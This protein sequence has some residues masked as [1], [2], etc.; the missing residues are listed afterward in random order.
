MTLLGILAVYAALFAFI[1]L[2]RKNPGWWLSQH[3]FS[4]WGPRTD[5]PCMTRR[6]L[7]GEGL[8][9]L[10]L[11][12]LCAA[13]FVTLAWV[14]DRLGVAE[15]PA[16]MATTFLAFIL[17]AMGFFAAGY[18]FVRGLFRSRRYVP[19]PDCHKEHTSAARS[20]QGR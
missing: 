11:G 5:V 9:F 4:Q 1:A 7:F 18:L 10:L 6:E 2:L 14:L 20:D 3:L 19:P 17:S 16:A 8:R 12:A 13:I 15:A